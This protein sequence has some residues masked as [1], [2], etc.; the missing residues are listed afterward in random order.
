MEKVHHIHQVHEMFECGDCLSP[1]S[2]HDSHSFSLHQL[3][4]VRVI[5]IK[6]VFQSLIQVLQLRLRIDLIFLVL[7]VPMLLIGWVERAHRPVGLLQDSQQ[8]VK[9]NF[10][11]QRLLPIFGIRYLLAHSAILYR[12]VKMAIFHSV[13]VFIEVHDFELV[14][15][16]MDRN[17]FCRFGPLRVPLIN[18]LVQTFWI[19]WVVF[20]RGWHYVYLCFSTFGTPVR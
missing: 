1:V 2:A 4:V 14:F 20:H 8:S 3:K 7:P 5:F 15:E 9:M 18:W 13:F 19:F 6:H 11:D 17:G 12:P 10:I 16:T